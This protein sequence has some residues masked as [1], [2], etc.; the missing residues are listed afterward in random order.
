MR[1]KRTRARPTAAPD[2][3]KPPDATGVTIDWIG[4]QETG[5]GGQLLPVWFVGGLAALRAAPFVAWRISRR[6][7]RVRRGGSRPREPQKRP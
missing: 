2:R 5:G 6:L 1:A 4:V 3:E 7:A